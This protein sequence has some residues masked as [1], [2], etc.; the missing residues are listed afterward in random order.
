MTLILRCVV[1]ICRL[2]WTEG[3]RLQTVFWDSKLP[4]L[5]HSLWM[6]FFC[7]SPCFTI[8]GFDTLENMYGRPVKSCSLVFI[9]CRTLMSSNAYIN[10]YFFFFFFFENLH[11]PVFLDCVLLHLAYLCPKFPDVYPL[12]NCYSPEEGE[13][14]LWNTVD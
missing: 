4:L 10:L 9:F 13:R 1:V 14:G 5:D 3:L 7:C 2:N 12:D 8:L 11:Q 6:L